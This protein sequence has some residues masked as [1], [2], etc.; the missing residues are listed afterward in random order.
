MK[1]RSNRPTLAKKEKKKRTHNN[2]LR[3]QCTTMM[4]THNNCHPLPIASLGPSHCPLPL[5]QPRL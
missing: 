1:H 2:E 5:N 4:A 3:Q